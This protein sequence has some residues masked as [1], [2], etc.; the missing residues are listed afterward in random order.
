[1]LRG[2]N[3]H[4][5]EVH[6][7]ISCRLLVIACDD[8][9]YAEIL[10]LDGRVVANQ[11]QVLC[12]ISQA[13]FVVAIEFGLGAHASDLLYSD[14]VVALRTTWISQI[15][16]IVAA[17]TGK[18]SVIAFLSQIRGRHRGRPWFLYFI[19]ASN[20]VVNIIVVV[21]I[22][23]SVPREQTTART[24]NFRALRQGYLKASFISYYFTHCCFGTC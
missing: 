5:L 12:I 11:V 16:G 21:L 6:Q 18:L 23:V 22:L 9:T 1:M 15:T 7:A 3:L 14:I 20:V 8:C 13:Y 19:G 2:E 24:V 4:Q 17:V 10:Y